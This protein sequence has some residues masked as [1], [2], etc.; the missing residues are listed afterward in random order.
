M[1]KQPGQNKTKITRP[2]PAQQ[3]R[4]WAVLPM[5][6]RKDLKV[7]F[8]VRGIESYRVIIYPNLLIF[9]VHPRYFSTIYNE[10][11][12]KPDHVVWI[13][14]PL[15]RWR[16]VLKMQSFD[17]RLGISRLVEGQGY[18]LIYRDIV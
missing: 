3:E 4:P 16:H 15:A 7:I 6:T 12:K 1:W 18:G 13:V 9:Q 5:E 8:A 11:E 2:F 14:E 10:Y 17:D